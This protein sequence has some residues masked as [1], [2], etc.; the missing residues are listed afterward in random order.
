MLGQNAS[1][2]YRIF[3]GARKLAWIKFTTLKSSPMSPVTIKI[4]NKKRTFCRLLT[5]EVFVWYLNDLTGNDTFVFLFSVDQCGKM[6]RSS[7]NKRWQKVTK[8]ENTKEVSF[9]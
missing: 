1:G 9:Q 8:I 2:T 7:L 6:C 4:L 5:L 3:S